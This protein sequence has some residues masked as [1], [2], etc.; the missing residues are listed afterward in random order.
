MQVDGSLKS[1]VAHVHLV[2]GPGHPEWQY[3]TLAIEVQGK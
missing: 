1:G 2:K 3:R